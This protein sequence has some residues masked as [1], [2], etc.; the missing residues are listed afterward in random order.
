[1]TDHPQNLVDVLCILL[2]DLAPF[3][4]LSLLTFFFIYLAGYELSSCRY[5][6]LIWVNSTY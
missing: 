1:M 4:L 2:H 5:N 3:L 6:L